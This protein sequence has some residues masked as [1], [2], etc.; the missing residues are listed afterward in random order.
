VFVVTGSRGLIAASLGLDFV[1]DDRMENC[2]D[3]VADSKARALLVWREDAKPSPA[4]AARLGI[5]VTAST[6]ACLEIL[7][8]IEGPAS[9]AN[10]V[11]RVKRL[12]GLRAP[13]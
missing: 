4:T 8:A 5:G 2:M 6:A 7:A 13:A 9:K 10:V 12:L 11:D 1:I 3:V